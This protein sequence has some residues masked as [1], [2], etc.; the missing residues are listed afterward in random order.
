MSELTQYRITGESA[1][2]IAASVEDAIKSGALE[3]GEPL[4]AVR[5]LATQLHVSPTTVAAALTELRTRG[6]IVTRARSHSH[7]SWRPPLATASLMQAIPSGARDLVSGNPD[8]A[9]LP[10]LKRILRR[11]DP[12]LQLYGGDPML[13]ELLELARAE[14]S[15]DRIEDEHLAI[16]S[17]ALDGVERVMQA[18]LRAGDIVAV[19]DPGFPGLFDVLRAMGLA[20]RPVGVDAQGMQPAA[21]QAALDDGVAAVVINPRGQN[22]TG[23][24]LD[25]DRANELQAI[26]AQAPDL[27]LVEDDHLGPIA[28]APRL[29][30]ATGRRRWAAARSVA[31]SLGPDLRLAILA[32][33]SQTISRVR[34]RQAVGPQWVSHILQRLVAMLWS[35]DEVTSTLERAA[36]AYRERAEW[37]VYALAQ[38]DIQAMPSTGITVWIP[39]PEEAPV[40]QSLLEQGFA[41]SPGAPYRLRS[42]PA[43]RVTTSTLQ[44]REAQELARA[45]ERALEP[46]VRTR[47]A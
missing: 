14:L 3:P 22:P 43:I 44:R 18:Q 1:R 33:D 19:E 20:L 12:P 39:V 5:K 32:G 27:L 34:G 9:L 15:A 26:L 29:T 13:G 24:A 23:A 17:G 41:V 25:K 8:P 36:G 4:P 37:L 46:T 10:D 45:I 11:M 40:I 35:Q 47:T 6:L 7:I 42:E 28:N 21:L 30:L 2:E 38:R 16:V 31:K